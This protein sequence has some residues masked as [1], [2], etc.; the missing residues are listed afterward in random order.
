MTTPARA[1]GAEMRALREDSAALHL[2][3]FAAERPVFELPE[4]PRRALPHVWAWNEYYPMLLRAA[5][6][7]DPDEAFRR[8]FMFANPGLRPRPF[9]TPTLDGACSLYNPG[10][11]APVHRHTPSASRLGLEGDGGFSTVAGEKCTLGRGDLVLTPNGTWHDF[12]NEGDGRIVFIDIV[13]DPLCLAL[14]GTFYEVGYAE[15]EP[16][17]NGGKAV[18]KRLQSVRAPLEHSRNLYAGGGVVPRFAPHERARDRDAS[19]MFVYRYEET[20]ARLAALRDYDASPYDGVI[21][22]YVN[23]VNGA[24][25][26]PSMSFHMQLLRR[27]EATATHRHT[28]GTVYCAVEGAGRTTVDGET[29]RWR[30]NDVFVVPGWTWHAHCAGEDEDAVL[31]S[32]SD[33]AALRKLGLYREQGQR[34]DGEIVEL[35][36]PAQ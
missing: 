23:P 13:N 22:E 19:P 15:P 3:E 2:L 29:L 16:G 8:S 14:G 34:G 9:M 5:E 30:R 7:I 4:P 17:A 32:V 25:A 24:P 27:G 11:T 12:G 1:Q 31:Y 18:A 26:M 33:E 21:V 6:L 28:A 35:A 36:W 20:R 10:E